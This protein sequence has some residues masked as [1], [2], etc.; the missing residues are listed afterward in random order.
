MRRSRQSNA[1]L[2]TLRTVLSSGTL[3]AV[4]LMSGGCLTHDWIDPSEVAGRTHKQNAAFLPVKILDNIDPR[5]EETN[6]EF[7]GAGDP[8]AEDVNVT[9]EDYRLNANDIVRITVSDLE[10]P[11]VQSLFEK[12]ISETGNISLPYVGT[13]RVV[14][15][16]EAELEKMIVRAYGPEGVNIIQNANVSVSVGEARG[17]TFSI[18]GAV[19]RPAQYAIL[20]SDFRVLDALV[21]AGDTTSPLIDTLYIIRKTG[22]ANG[23]GPATAPTGKTPAAPTTDELAPSKP[24]SPRSSA[25]KAGVKSPV[26]IAQAP[27]DDLAPAAPTTPA[28]PAAPAKPSVPADP[29]AKPPADAGAETGNADSRIINVGGQDITADPGA[30][31]AAPT[32]EEG[33]FEFNSIAVTKDVRVIRI[34]LDKLKKGDLKYNIPIR[35]NDRLIAK[36]LDL[37]EYY[38]GG[39]VGQP[40]AYSLTG[41]Q[42]TLKQAVIAARMLDQLAIPQRTDIVRRINK[43]EEVFV[44]VDLAQIFEGKRPDIYL[45]PDDQVMVGTN[46]LAPFIASVRGAFRLS[47]GLGFLYDK[48][49]AYDDN[50]QNN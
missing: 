50:N 8:T 31:A 34:A 10:G 1:S 46:A 45:K 37:G 20:Q 40:G 21:L 12:R 16:N 41:R 39:H 42:I 2:R 18:M 5:V 47:Y 22:D 29:I 27:A 26:Y 49:Y 48:N 25:D 7:L 11:G 15:L 43:N 32:P 23:T 4:L 19:Q 33:T 6:T 3:A 24:S 9:V 28:R 14:G 17:R 13:M 38:M 35:P 44:R 30:A 36:P